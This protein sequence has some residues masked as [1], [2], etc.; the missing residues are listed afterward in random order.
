MYQHQKNTLFVYFKERKYTMTNGTFQM[1]VGQAQKFERAVVRNGLDASAVEFL[2]QG[3]NLSK[4]L[5]RVGFNDEADTLVNIKDFFQNSAT[6]WI[7]PDFTCW[8]LNR[9]PQEVPENP[10]ELVKAFDLSKTMSDG[11]II[12]HAKTLGFDPKENSVTL[13]QIKAKIEAQ[14]NCIDGE[15]L[16]N[17]YANIFYVLIDGVLFTVDVNCGVDDGRW[18]V[19][20]H[21]CG[22]DGSWDA[23]RRVFCNRT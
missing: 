16:T 12:S 19:C 4:A 9:L 5:Q 2:S 8:I 6:L 1:T 20:A 22:Q 17:G 3:K 18:S 15:M 14:P 23:G 21:K 7:H 11:E 13:G 10:S